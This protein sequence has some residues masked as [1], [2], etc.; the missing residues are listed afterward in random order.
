MP[1]FHVGGT[2]YALLAISCGARIVMMRMPDPAAVL[3][4]LEAERI[5]HTFLVPALLAAMTQVPGVAERDFSA[6]T[7]AVLRRLADAAARDAGL[8]RRSSPASCTRSTA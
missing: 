7:V 6:L 4:M 2:S 1:L 3:E 5:T 8:P